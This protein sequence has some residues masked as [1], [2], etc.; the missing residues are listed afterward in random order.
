MTSKNKIFIGNLSF[1]MNESEL[2]QY[3]SGFGNIEEVVIPTDRESGRSRGF[4]FVTFESQ[5]S[6]Q[7][8]LAMDGQDVG[9][10]N[11]SVKIAQDKRR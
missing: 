2:E 10:R 3:F 6:V 1:K 7:E 8:A 5:D 4:A 9:G 11:I